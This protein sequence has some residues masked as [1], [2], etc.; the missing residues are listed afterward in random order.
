MVSGD[1]ISGKRSLWLA[2]MV[3]N[4]SAK[5]D[6]GLIPGRSPEKGMATL[7][8]YCCLE[9]PISRVKPSRLQSMWVTESDTTERPTLFFFLGL[10]VATFLPVLTEPLLDAYGERGQG[11][12]GLSFLLV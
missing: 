3:K 9:N 12:R 6:L 11:G 10:Q 5:G 7:L 1:L 8:Q 4:L 2:R